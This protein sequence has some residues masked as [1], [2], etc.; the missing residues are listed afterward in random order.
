[1]DA[2]ELDAAELRT[3]QGPLKQR[4]REDPATAA[5]TVRRSAAL[6]GS[7]FSI[8][9]DTWAGPVRG[10]LHPATGG[11]GSDAC[12]ADMLL[13]ALLA[14]AGVTL[15]SVAHAMGIGIRTASLEAEGSFDARGTLAVSRDAP[16]G[17]TGVRVTAEVD[18][19]ADDA[20]L[21]KLAELTDR[22]CVVGQSLREPVELVV[23][24][25]TT[26]A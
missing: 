24:R 22:Y 8:L 10:G 5:V 6:D 12:S 1:M 11:D 3:R 14:C 16:V 26:P 19:D 9:V 18:T 7:G 23:R 25:V 2:A 15:R 20:Q 21:D 13:E 17:V 4:Y